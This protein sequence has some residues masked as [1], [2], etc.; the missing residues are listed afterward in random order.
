MK[1]SDAKS[2]AAYNAI[3]DQVDR[4]RVKLKMARDE[5]R[6]VASLAEDELRFLAIQIW[7]DLKEALNLE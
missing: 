1:L 7:G 6:D 2:Q 4:L 5:K 3:A